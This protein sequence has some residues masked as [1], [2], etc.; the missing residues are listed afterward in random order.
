MSLIMSVCTYHIRSCKGSDEPALLKR[1][2]I[3]KNS[4]KKLYLKA[5]NGA[6]IRNRYNQ[7]PH[8]FKES[9]YAYAISN[10]NTFPVP[11]REEWQF[12]LCCKGNNKEQE[13]S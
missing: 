9:R 13:M 8:M 2:D 5:S 10:K 1:R 7:V 11:I 12:Y 6:K 4:G 3:D